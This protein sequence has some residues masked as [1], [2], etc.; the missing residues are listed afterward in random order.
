MMR[1]WA[2]VVA[3]QQGIATLRCEQK[4][5]CS[6]CQANHTC[7]MKVLDK[8]GPEAVYDLQIA[9]EQPLVVGQRVELG[10]P[11]ASLLRSALLVYILPLFTLLVG[12]SVL[13]QLFPSDI[14]L[15]A[16]GLIGG[17]CGFLIAGFYAAKTE[18]NGAYH[19]I[20][21]QIAIPL[22][23]PVLLEN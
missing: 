13:N 16:G 1:E 6:G 23:K 10:I 11:E 4:S 15:I 19:P 7:G 9:I 12:A 22:S 2:T 8:L 18:R 14:S 3:W 20:V 17:Y 21:L 5:A